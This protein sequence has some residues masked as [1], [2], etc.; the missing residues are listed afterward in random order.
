MP[1]CPHCHKFIETQRTPSQNNALHLACEMLANQLNESGLDQRVVL[2][3]SYKAWWDKDSVKKHLFKPFMRKIAHVESTK[4][5][6]KADGKIG[7]IWD[8]LMRELGEHFG[9]EYIPF[10]HTCRRCGH[11][12]C[13]CE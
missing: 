12:E 5:L 2:K 6:K 1:K 9:L 11:M 4:E 8:T 13:Q 7:E 10:P 3:P